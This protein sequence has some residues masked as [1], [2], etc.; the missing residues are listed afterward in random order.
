MFIFSAADNDEMAKNVMFEVSGERIMNCIK[1]KIEHTGEEKYVFSGIVESLKC[2]FLNL[3]LGHL[4]NLL[5]FLFPLILCLGID[6]EWTV[7]LIS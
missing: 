1:C 3:K 6:M 4:K 5:I 2:I 7:G